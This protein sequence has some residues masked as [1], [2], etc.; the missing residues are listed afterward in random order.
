MKKLGQISQLLLSIIV[1]AMIFTFTMDPVTGLSMAFAMPTF[2]DLDFEDGQDN[3]AGT[4]LLAYYIPA[5]DIETLPGYK[6]P[7]SALGD[8]ATVDTDFVCKTGKNFLSLYASPDTGKIDDN[9]IE[10]KDTN[11]YESIYEFFF[12]KNDAASLGFQ[13][14]APTSKFVVIVLEADGN[15][16]ILGIKPGVPAIIASVAGSSGN[17]S[18]G[19]KGAT[20]QFKSHQN[21]PA[22]IYTGAIPLTPAS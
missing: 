21:G 13:R 17:Q 3:M 19:E 20:F 10:G 15:K 1:I 16:R 8:Y 14:I 2:A 22:P 4:Q 6:D 12:P 5:G 7:P 18:G 9:K 11:A